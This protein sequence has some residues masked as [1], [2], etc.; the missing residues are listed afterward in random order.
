M[1]VLVILTLAIPHTLVLEETGWPSAQA[2]EHRQDWWYTALSK[3][4]I[5]IC[6]EKVRL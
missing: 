5:V 2:C 3:E 6:Y 4:Y 1:W